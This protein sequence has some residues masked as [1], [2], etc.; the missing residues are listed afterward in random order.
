MEWSRLEQIFNLKLK[1][2]TKIEWLFTYS[3]IKPVSEVKKEVVMISI[4]FVLNNL[5][6]K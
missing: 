1:A 3:S 2:L 5:R 4:L 6:L